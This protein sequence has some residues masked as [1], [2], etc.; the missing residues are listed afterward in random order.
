M[1]LLHSDA[2]SA[3]RA[4]AGSVV[5]PGYQAASREVLSVSGGIAQIRVDGILTPRADEWIEWS[6][7]ANTS[8]EDIERAVAS[9]NADPSVTSIAL[10][11][12]SSPGG[13][14]EGMIPAM[15]ALRLSEKK[16]TAYVEEAAHSAAY[17]LI[18]QAQGG[19]Y[20][21]HR[22]T[23]FGSVG[24]AVSGYIN[25][26]R[27]DLTNTD[28]P[29]KRPDLA[30]DEGK[31]VVRGELDQ[32]FAIF[33]ETIA[34]G[35]GIDKKDVVKSF[36]KGA[37]FPAGIALANGMIDGVGLPSGGTS[38]AGQTEES[39]NLQELKAAHPDL[40][41]AIAAEAVKGEQERVNAHLVLGDASG[42][43]AQA[44]KDIQAGKKVTQETNAYH[45]AA[46]IRAARAANLVGDNASADLGA[47]AAAAVEVSDEDKRM[48]AIADGMTWAEEGVL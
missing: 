28:S 46:S 1:Y 22:A 38:S 43:M 24:V 6:Y 18:S 29:D 31:A 9:A 15:D 5:P 2:L 13:V 44:V 45:T 34:Q 36:G 42:D 8:Y 19:I 39:M 33:A 30:T 35:R 20:A 7:G 47:T 3:I 10:V 17:G 48:Q 40:V 12:G 16:V 14:I 23:M 4:A 25:E 21:K 11:V 41:G 32:L 37:S 26:D 27:V